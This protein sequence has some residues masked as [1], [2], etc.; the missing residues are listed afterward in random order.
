MYLQPREQQFTTQFMNLHGSFGYLEWIKKT[1][2]SFSCENSMMRDT[3]GGWMNASL[4]C[5]YKIKYVP[6]VT[7]ICPHCVALVLALAESHIKSS[8]WTSL[9]F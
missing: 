5:W 7:S 4:H 9:F 8:S 3:N 2:I 6:V 1:E